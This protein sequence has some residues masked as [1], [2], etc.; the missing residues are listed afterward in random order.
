MGEMSI[1]S[2]C[3]IAC[4]ALLA[5][6]VLGIAGCT[7]EK[8]ATA[9]GSKGDVIAKVAPPA[10]KLWSDVVGKTPEGGYRMGNPAAAIKLVEYC[11]L[12]C[13]HCAEFSEK[14][15]AEL[16]NTYVASGRVSY[17]FRNFVRDA[18]DVTA[19]MLTQCGTPEGFFPLTEQAFKNQAAMFATVQKAGDPA[20]TAA[21]A[22]PADK[23]GVALAQL[24]GLTDFFTSRGISKDKANAC[25][26]DGGKA[27]A[28][29]KATEDQSEQYKINGTPTFLING[30]SIG[31]MGWEELRSKLQNMGAR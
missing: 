4:A 15:S 18:I 7:K 8:E 11:S 12:T 2:I 13:S 21:M 22:L 9:G 17:E 5:P 28:L 26:A 29:A 27:Q 25:M 16:R 3:R 20:Y 14:A 31:S 19:A 10:G 23:R 24:T 30:A 6:L 1:R